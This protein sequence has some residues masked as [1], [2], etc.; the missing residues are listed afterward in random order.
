MFTYEE[1]ESSRCGHN[2]KNEPLSSS[3]RCSEA[4]TIH[5]WNA[6]SRSVQFDSHRSHASIMTRLPYALTGI[7]DPI[8]EAYFINT[9]HFKTVSVFKKIWQKN[10][11]GFAGRFRA[12]SSDSLFRNKT[13]IPHYYIAKNSNKVWFQCSRN[14]TVLILPDSSKKNSKFLE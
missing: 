12:F 9:L 8:L 4:T 11:T 10:K 6:P 13:R 7:E 14:Q 5:H 2:N 3:N 1:G